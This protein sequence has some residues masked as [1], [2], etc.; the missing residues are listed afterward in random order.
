M[1]L[2]ELLGTGNVKE[3]FRH[4]LNEMQATN[5]LLRDMKQTLELIATRLSADGQRALVEQV[6]KELMNRG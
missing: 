1:V 6:V 4:L 3:T 2:G 5:A